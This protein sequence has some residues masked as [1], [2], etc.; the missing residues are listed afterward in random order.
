MEEGS[1]LQDEARVIICVLSLK[2]PK[3][4]DVEKEHINRRLF[5]LFRALFFTVWPWLGM[6]RS[7]FQIFNYNDLTD[8]LDTQ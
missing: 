6:F 5:N 2:A 3:P 8:N 1:L 4:G 7:L